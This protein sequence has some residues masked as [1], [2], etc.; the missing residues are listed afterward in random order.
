MTVLLRWYGKQ[1]AV[2]FLQKLMRSLHVFKAKIMG[3]Q[4]RVRVGSSD[5]EMM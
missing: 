3:L 4:Q 2:G 1:S 5:V